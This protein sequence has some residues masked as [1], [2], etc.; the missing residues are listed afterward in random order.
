MELKRRNQLEEALKSS[1]AP[2]E[3]L[4]ILSETTINSERRRERSSSRDKGRSE[5]PYASERE[6]RSSV[7]DR[8]SERGGRVERE[9]DPSNTSVASGGAPTP[10]SQSGGGGGGGAGNGGS[11]GNGGAAGQPI[12]GNG[13]SGAKQP[14]NYPGLDLMASGAFWQNY[15][16]EVL[17]FY[18]LTIFNVYHKV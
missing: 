12:E 5:S 8:S 15:S 11:G 2:A 14:W 6:G 7:V 17:L 9:R 3:A 4:R 13:G 18:A 10:Q 1:G 16:G